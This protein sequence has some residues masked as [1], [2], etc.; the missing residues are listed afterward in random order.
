MLRLLQS[1]YY[2]W[3]RSRTVLLS[4]GLAIIS[5]ILFPL[6]WILLSGTSI[7]RFGDL[8]DDA[9]SFPSVWITC[10]F[11]NLIPVQLMSIIVI[12]ITC[13]SFEEKTYRLH[14]LSGENR[15]N[16]WQRRLSIIIMLTI[17]ST[18]LTILI[19]WV[20]GA[21]IDPNAYFYISRFAIA[22]LF[23]F[24]LQVF[25]YLSFALLISC[26]LKKFLLSIIFY[27]LW[28]SLIERVFASLLNYISP[29]I[30]IGNLFPGKIIEYIHPFDLDALVTTNYQPYNYWYLF[31]GFAWLIIGN[32]CSFQIFRKTRL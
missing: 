30:M 22:S 28:F 12:V 2:I 16:L 10:T 29:A 15:T 4:T 21:I 6:L 9:Y 27:I 26:L 1:E 25:L 7:D 31:A 24:F 19:S 18:F 8:L 14:F 13:K 11:L 32:L 23:I 3:S 20:C 17:L 5:L